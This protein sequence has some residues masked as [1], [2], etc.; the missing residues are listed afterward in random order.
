MNTIKKLKPYIINVIIILS[1]FILVLILNHISPFGNKMLGDSDAIFQYKPMLYEM[2]KKIQDGDFFNYT[3]N[4]GLGSPRI[5]EFSYYLSSPLNF[6][7]IFFHTADTMFL[8][9]ILIKLLIGTIIMT[10][11]T[12]TKT[13]NPYIITIATISYMFSSYLI[14]YYCLI[15]WL[16]IIIL[17]PLFQKG[18]EDLLDK[19]KPNLYIISLALITICNFFLAFSIYIYTIA[20]FIIYELF[21]KKNTK[22]EK[23][24][25]F[26]RIAIYTILTFIMIFLWIYILFDIY[27]KTG[28]SSINAVKSDYTLTFIDLLRSILY[29]NV[30]MNGNFEGRA[31]PDLACNHFVLMNII[32]Y[33]INNKISKK[34][35]KYALIII[36]LLLLILYI[37]PIDYVLNFFHEVRGFPF[38]YAYIF[39]FLSINMMIQN[40]KTFTKE[41]AKKILFTI[42]IIA[43][44]I[45]ITRKETEQTIIITNIIFTLSL[46][47]LFL[48]YANNKYHK[49]LLCFILAIESFTITYIQLPVSDD[50][51]NI[52]YSKYTKEN[53]KYRNNYALDENEYINTNLYYN[54][55][56]TYQFTSLSY[57]SVHNMAEALGCEIHESSMLCSDNNQ[58]TNMLF[59]IENDYYLE[60]IFAVN[61]MITMVDTNNTDNLKMNTENIILGMT[62]I[63]DLYN[64]ETLY[65]EEED[66]KYTFLTNHDFYLIEVPTEDLGI[67]IIPQI[68]HKFSQ[69]KEHGKNTAIIYT[70][71]EE[72]LKEIY[73]YLSKNQIHY[74]YYN[75]N[76][77]EGTIHVDNNQMIYTSIPYDISWEIK[78]DG[79]KIKQPI[80]LMNSLIGIEVEPGDHTI[81]MEYK[82]TNYIGPGIVSLTT[83]IGYILFCIKKKK[84]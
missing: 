26:N 68:Y 61:K 34:D 37:K 15:T 16:D 38:R 12:K 22:K 65:A 29:G 31:F 24:N 18:L 66:D 40:L 60:K 8:S 5:F 81:S 14:T 50:K 57:S 69:S 11:Y 17:F 7:A 21:Y 63:E 36:I 78:I 62:G 80:I 20:Y 51:E 49:I 72:K 56:V 45:F 74:T 43:F 59:N 19:K 67:A 64:Q 39:A 3:F 46:L 27:I 47:V 13:D 54:K 84:V 1:L 2:I 33:F 55:K 41:D 48:F 82:H 44:L 76:K 6:I 77:I 71:K 73:D 10:Y 9:T 42:P 58:I 79:K 32:F 70:L 83:I 23:W 75:D 52:D 35:K 25:S 28:V 30:S 4:N 53:V